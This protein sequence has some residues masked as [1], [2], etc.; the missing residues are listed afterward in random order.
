MPNEIVFVYLIWTHPDVETPRE[1]LFV[2]INVYE[3]EGGE[4]SSAQKMNNYK[5]PTNGQVTNIYE[6][7][8][9][10]IYAAN[11]KPFDTKVYNV[12]NESY[13]G[14]SWERTK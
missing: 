2:Y 8:I 11:G 5:N 9:L 1:R 7:L 3:E 6:R 14:Q 10:F 13:H 12:R 4:A